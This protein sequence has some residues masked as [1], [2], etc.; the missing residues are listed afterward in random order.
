MA[1]CVAGKVRPVRLGP[2]APHGQPFDLV[3]ERS[4]ELVGRAL[5]QPKSTHGIHPTED[6]RGVR[7]LLGVS[8]SGHRLRP[9]RRGRI[10]RQRRA[11]RGEAGSQFDEVG[12]SQ[13]S[14]LPDSRERCNLLV[15]VALDVRYLAD[16]LQGRFQLLGIV[17]DTGLQLGRVLPSNWSQ[18]CIAKGRAAPWRCC[19]SSELRFHP[20]SNTLASASFLLHAAMVLSSTVRSASSVLAA[21]CS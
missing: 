2:P 8:G 19:R 10:M 17:I 5:Q 14:G 20:L 13:F 12:D 11:Q 7:D 1:D 16:K 15:R 18:S 4:I 9:N 21:C 6:G 3:R